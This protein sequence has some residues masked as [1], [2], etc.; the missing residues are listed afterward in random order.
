MQ[1]H[2]SKPGGQR[3]GPFSLEQ[4]KRDLAQGKYGDTDYW[5]WYDGLPGW[6]PLYTVP[7]ISDKTS[8]TEAPTVAP[9]AEASAAPGGTPELPATPEV[10]RK[11]ASGLPF[12]ALEQIFILTTGEGQ[13]ATRSEVTTRI[14]ED[15]VGEEFGRIRQQV[16]RDVLVR[17][18][19]VE[20]VHREGA[21][22]ESVWRVMAGLKPELVQQARAGAYRICVRVFPIES[23]DLV[24]AFFFYRKTAVTGQ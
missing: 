19:A 11:L 14:F 13:A 6:V 23:R 18:D 9:P 4:I 15:V 5:A 3:E 20:R 24:A 10:T 7:G 2:L 21:I 22:P 1:I 8:P 16:P 12:S 17:C